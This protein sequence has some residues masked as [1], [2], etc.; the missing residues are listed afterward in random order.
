MLDLKSP[1]ARRRP[2]IKPPPARARLPRGYYRRMIERLPPDSEI[3]LRDVTWDDYEALLNDV[4][5]AAGWRV[6][7]QEGEIRVM[8]L[9]AKHE[10]YS[11]LLDGMVRLV[12]LR[13]RIKILSFGSMTIKKGKAKGAEPDNCFYIQS[14]HLIGHKL[15]INFDRDPPP[16]VVAEIDIHHKSDDKFA[17]YAAL[18]VPELWL[19]DEKKMRFYALQGGKYVEI[20][21]SRALPMLAS[22]TLTDFLNRNRTQDQYEVLLAF[23]EWLNKTNPQ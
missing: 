23:E 19:Y 5:E 15:K 21:R 1:S 7:Y 16:D 22:K 8:V 6:S 13:R 2:S 20:K 12:S 14:A 17:L 9:S 11:T 3:V 4:G 10:N 18:G